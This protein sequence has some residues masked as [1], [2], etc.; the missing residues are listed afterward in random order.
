MKRRIFEG[1]MIL[2]FLG[3][4]LVGCGIEKV[5]EKK[6]ADLEYTVCDESRL[7]KEL[8][9]MIEEKKKDPFRFVYR[10]K[11]YIYIVEG[12]GTQ[13][14]DD[15]SVSLK[16][17]YRTKNAV[18]VD[19]ELMASEEKEDERKGKL[20]KKMTQEKLLRTYPYIAIKCP[21]QDEEVYFK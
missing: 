11:D 14:R 6:I 12:Y 16:E 15:L 5:D 21:V 10:T 20:G 4:V 18:F 13:E 8:M 1:V 17:L 9:D 2:V 19:T 7:P 3:S